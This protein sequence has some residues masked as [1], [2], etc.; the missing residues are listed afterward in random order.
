MNKALT[1]KRQIENRKEVELVYDKNKK[2][3]S[4]KGRVYYYEK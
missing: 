1:S 3:S 4:R 2:N